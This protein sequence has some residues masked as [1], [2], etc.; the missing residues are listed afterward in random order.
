MIYDENLEKCKGILCED[1][2]RIT[3]SGYRDKT[4]IILKPVE[5][6][7]F[8][9]PYC[10]V[11]QKND[12]RRR[13][14]DLE[15]IELM[16]KNV[17]EFMEE[18]QKYT[19]EKNYS[20]KFIG[21]E[22]T[23]IDLN[24]YIKQ[25]KLHDV[26]QYTISTNLYRPVE[27]FKE[28]NDTINKMGSKLFISAGFHGVE[29]TKRIG[30]LESYAQKIKS[31]LDF[32]SLKIVGVVSDETYD[33]VSKMC[34]LVENETKTSK[35]R[36]K[37]QIRINKTLKSYDRSEKLDQAFSLLREK[38]SSGKILKNMEVEY[39]DGR[40]SV[41]TTFDL[42]AAMYDMPGVC[43]KGWHCDAIN[44]FTKISIK[45]YDGSI[46]TCPLSKPVGNIYI[47]DFEFLK[48]Y[49]LNDK[50][51]TAE[52]CNFSINNNTIQRIN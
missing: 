2:K 1:L 44:N 3:C 11:S 28:I 52:H 4:E 35:Y 31:I 46:D 42:I 10:I 43:L 18:H 9:C 24:K 20:V 22:P 6:C 36:L 19:G 29:Y 17:P 40:K 8:R 41:G 48:A 23:L 47:K 34:E 7:N 16:F 12:D 45:G 25:M 15:K 30:D 32:C 51:C 27:Y 39:L 5:S 37:I 49:G 14:I 50:V 33:I 26:Q 38:Y 21:G 13:K